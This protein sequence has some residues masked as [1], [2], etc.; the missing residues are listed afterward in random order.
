MF[1]GVGDPFLNQEVRYHWPVFGILKYVKPK[2]K[3]FT[4]HIYSY[5]IGNVYFYTKKHP[6]LTGI[7]Y[8]TI[9][10]MIMQVT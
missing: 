3:A 8:K 5:E 4:R 10:L 9:I 2:T 1:S 6:Q 7:Q